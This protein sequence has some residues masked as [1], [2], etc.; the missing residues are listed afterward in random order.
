MIWQIMLE[1]ET[2]S[3]PIQDIIAGLFHT[4]AITT[5]DELVCWG[6]NRSGQL[7]NMV[8]G[9]KSYP[10]SVRAPF[11]M[12]VVCDCVDECVHASV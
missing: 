10:T 4:C 3:W 7:A 12:F 9:E 8:V 1:G 5:R 2:A 6:D 11:I